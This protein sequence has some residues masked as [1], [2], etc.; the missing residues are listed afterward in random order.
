M[1]MYRIDK[2][3]DLDSSN[4][5]DFKDGRSTAVNTA[6]TRGGGGGSGAP[7]PPH[8]LF[9]FSSLNIFNLIF[10]PSPPKKTKLIK[11][12]KAH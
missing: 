7:L 1:Y 6:G 8:R 3:T 12:T 5:H 4:L 2:F 11:R 9:F 10:A